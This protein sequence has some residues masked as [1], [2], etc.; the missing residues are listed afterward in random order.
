MNAEKRYRIRLGMH[1]ATVVSDA[2][3]CVSKQLWRFVC[4]KNFIANRWTELA[5]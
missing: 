2:E 3:T 1:S 4:D 5:E